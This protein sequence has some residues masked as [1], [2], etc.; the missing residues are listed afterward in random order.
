MP[1]LTFNAQG[2]LNHLQPAGDLPAQGFV[3]WA[4]TRQELEGQWHTLTEQLKAWG[5]PAPI[6][7]HQQDLL[8][9]QHPSHYDYTSQYDLVIFRRLY[10]QQESVESTGARHS[11]ATLLQRIATQAVGFLVFDRVLVTVHDAECTTLAESLRRFGHSD[12]RRP[13]SPADLMLRMTNAMVDTYLELRKAL[14]TQLEAWQNELLDP[15]TRFVNWRALLAARNDLQAL[16]DVCDEQHDAMQEWL[17]AFQEQPLSAFAAAGEAARAERDVLLA[18]SRDVIEHINRVLHH[19]RRLETS[20]ETAVQMHFNAQ[21]NRTND[22]MRTL[23]ALTAI[24]LP[25]NLITGF[26][27]M[28]FDFLPLIHEQRGLWVAVAIMAAVGVGLG[29]VFWRKRYLSRTSR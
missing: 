4:L 25:L 16:E 26:F 15:R 3:W 7:L 24:F 13:S 17:D 11:G 8:N 9:A 10:L 29:L 20:A 27:G 19:V 1:F 2:V 6:E 28:N 14:S 12:A 22:I 18:R 5:L 23:T 21:G